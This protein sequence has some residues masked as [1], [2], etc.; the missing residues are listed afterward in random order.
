[1]V[2]FATFGWEEAT[3]SPPLQELL[4]DLLVD[5]SQ[6]LKS[7][8][9]RRGSFPPVAGVASY[10]STAH[11]PRTPEQQKNTSFSSQRSPQHSGH[12]RGVTLA[13]YLC[14]ILFMPSVRHTTTRMRYNHRSKNAEKM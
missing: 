4:W 5:Q 10:I 2:G 14:D 3:T 8:R 11:L 13:F 12:R 1:M 9:V 7:P 6:T